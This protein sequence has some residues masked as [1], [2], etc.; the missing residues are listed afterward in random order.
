MEVNGQNFENITF[1]KALEI[2]RNNTHLALTVKTNIFGEFWCKTCE[3]VFCFGGFF[4]I[5][6]RKFVTMKKK[7]VKCKH[8]CLS[9]LDIFKIFGVELQYYVL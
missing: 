8:F 5:E 6:K 4:V 7:I 3:D 9:Y 1:V 2:L